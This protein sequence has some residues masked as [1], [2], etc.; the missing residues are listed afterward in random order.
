M[1][2]VWCDKK[3]SRSFDLQLWPAILSQLSGVCEVL[4][5]IKRSLK[6]VLTDYILHTTLPKIVK[7]F[8]YMVAEYCCRSL[9]IVDT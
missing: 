9:Y 6:C 8:C 3:L 5:Y 2:P 4:I 7:G 1:T